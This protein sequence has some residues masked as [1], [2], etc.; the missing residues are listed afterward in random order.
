MFLGGGI[1]S[2]LTGPRAGKISDRLGR[3]PLI[4]ASLLGT[5]AV[6]VLTTVLTTNMWIASVL[7]VVV[8]ALFSMRMSPMQ[9]L[10]TA[11]VPAQ[12]RGTL[13]SL[14]IAIGQ[15]GMSIGGAIAGPVYA[16]SGFFL[17]TAVAACAMLGAAWVVFYALPEP[18]LRTQVAESIPKP[19]SLQ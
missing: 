13:L 17:S 18:A 4:V 14:T 11:L 15:I 3:K 2:V 5:A 9:A 8:M 6:F 12:R 1:A 10:L 16:Y 19:I 7:F